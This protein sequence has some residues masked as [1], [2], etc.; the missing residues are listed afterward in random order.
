M[1]KKPE[2]L[3]GYWTIAGDREPMG[4]TEV[5]EYSLR[6]RV[7]AASAAGYT[8]LGLV[9]QDIAYNREKIGLKGMKRLFDDNGIKHVEVEFLG[10]W[11]ETGEKR[12]ESDR[13]RH[14]LTEAAAE[15]GARDI[16]G[17]GQMYGETID[18]ELYAREFAQWCDEAKAVG[19]DVAIEVLPFTN[20]RDLKTSKKILDLAGRDNGGLC[21]DIWHMARGNIPYSEVA[22]FPLKYIK[23]VE[24]NDAMPKVKESMWLDTI[25]ERVYPGEGCFDVPAFIRAIKATGWD[26][27]WSVEVLSKKYR[28]TSLKD[29]AKRSFDTTIVAVCRSGN[30]SGSAARKLA[31]A[32]VSVYNLAGGM[33]AWREAG[34]PVI[35]D[36][37]TD[38]AVL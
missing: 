35:R 26:D 3:A 34:Q 23:S 16:K 28:V 6:E 24:L 20:I 14:E 25:R 21:I 8:G 38:G 4:P 1:S 11:F 7:E 12:R 31:A 22:E 27:F 15:L 9:I 36:D 13:I 17:S 30:R 19:A 37:G 10:D 32:G 33:K 29:Q 18:I 5:S 2:L